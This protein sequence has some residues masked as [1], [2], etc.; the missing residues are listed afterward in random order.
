[1][2]QKS[3]KPNREQNGIKIDMDIGQITDRNLNLRWLRK[4]V[5]PVTTPRS[6]PMLVTLVQMFPYS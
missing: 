2:A 6:P 5:I 3:N 1:M 4:R